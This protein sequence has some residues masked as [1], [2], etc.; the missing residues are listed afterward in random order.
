MSFY[1]R[2]S[3]ADRGGRGNQGMRLYNKYG[4]AASHSCL[5]ALLE[6]IC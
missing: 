5:F 2:K 3:E 6:K 4:F 1:R